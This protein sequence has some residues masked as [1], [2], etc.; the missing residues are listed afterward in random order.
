[1]TTTRTA[2]PKYNEDGIEIVKGQPV[3]ECE[4]C[5]HLHYAPALNDFIPCNVCACEGQ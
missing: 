5:G 2:A 1:M 3:E 4:E